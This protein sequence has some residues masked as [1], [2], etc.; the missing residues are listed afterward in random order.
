MR[1]VWEAS[2]RGWADILVVLVLNGLWLW[3]LGVFGRGL[4]M[5]MVVSGTRKNGA[6]TEGD[7]AG[8]MVELEVQRRRG[9]RA[10]ILYYCLI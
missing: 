4:V 3:F 1:R 10:A 9:R 5:V 8:L 7:N 6:M 2:I